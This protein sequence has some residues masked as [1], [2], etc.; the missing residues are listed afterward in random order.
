M[1]RMTPFLKRRWRA[2]LILAV[3][4]VALATLAAF[5]FSPG[6]R[7]TAVARKLRF[8]EKARKAGL[9][10]AEERVEGVAERLGREPAE[11]H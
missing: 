2:L 6:L 5:A 4:I 9:P 11:H 7:E 10:V 8:W 3:L 1:K